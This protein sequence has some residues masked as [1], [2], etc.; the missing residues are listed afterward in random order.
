M[1]SRVHGRRRSAAAALVVLFRQAEKKIA[2]VL[3][4]RV[5]LARIG[6]V[7]A[8]KDVTSVARAVRSRFAEPALPAGVEGAV[9]VGSTTAVDAGGGVSTERACR[10]AS[11]YGCSRGPLAIAVRIRST[12]V[13]VA[14]VARGH[15]S[16]ASKVRIEAADTAAT[17]TVGALRVLRTAH[18]IEGLTGYPHDILR[19]ARAFLHAVEA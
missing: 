18:R 8:E 10:K 17:R 16:A 9:R 13:V 3:A 7:G 15:C 1:Q 11:R 14:A 12:R 2:A 5:A 6:R 4:L 19:R